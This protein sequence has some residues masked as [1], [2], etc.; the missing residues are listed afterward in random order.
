MPYQSLRASG[1]RFVVRG[2]EVYWLLLWL[3]K[4]CKDVGEIALLPERKTVVPTNSQE[5]RLRSI[6]IETHRL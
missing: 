6:I 5:F 4:A 3:V 2:K 1:I